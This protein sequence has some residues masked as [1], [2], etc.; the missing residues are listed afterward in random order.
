MIL[1]LNFKME[2]M[3]HVIVVLGCRV[4]LT[5]GDKGK[6]GVLSHVY[7][8][9]MES[10]K[11]Y[12]EITEKKVIICT[13][14]NGEAEIMKKFLVGNG[15]ETN[16]IVCEPL[17]KNTI[18]NCILSY[19]IINMYAEKEKRLDLHLVTDEYHMERS[20]TIFSHFKSLLN[21]PTKF[22]HSHS[23]KML[24]YID[25]PTEIQKAEIKYAYD[26]D[27]YI[28]KICLERSLIEYSNR[29]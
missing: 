4:V 25:N 23:S 19:K 8:R 7:G 16:D 10:I 1:K 6:I 24:D 21:Y 18:E 26:K 12:N 13:G 15:I 14:H 9:L 11:V 5:G 17:A 29:A 22:L 2:K 27:I 20:K 3:V 28:I